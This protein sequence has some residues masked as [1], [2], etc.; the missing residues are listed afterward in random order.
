MKLRA[1]LLSV[2]AALA[3][4]SLGPGGLAPAAAAPGSSSSASDPAAEAARETAPPAPAAARAVSAADSAADQPLGAF[5]A[6]PSQL[7]QAPASRLKHESS[8]FC[9]GPARAVRLGEAQ[10]RIMYTTTDS[11]GAIT[12]V[13]G[14][15]LES[16][17]PWRAPCAT[18]DWAGPA[19][20]LRSGSRAAPRAAGPQLQPASWLPP[21][22][23]ISGCRP[24]RSV[25]LPRI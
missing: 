18:P 13:T 24:S 21:A 19:R 16:G 25:P 17:S 20:R 2:T 12:P 8:P 1:S 6:A 10:S 4:L 7:P 22:R 5:Y 3:A 11:D 9:L 15:F 23:P 14:S